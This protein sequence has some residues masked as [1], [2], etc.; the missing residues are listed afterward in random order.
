MLVAILGAVV[1]AYGYTRAS[2]ATDAER[3]QA[4]RRTEPLIGQWV[5]TAAD[6][7]LFR[8]QRAVEPKLRAGVFIGSIRRNE[9]GLRWKRGLSPSRAGAEPVTVVL[10]LEDELHPLWADIGRDGVASKLEETLR[11]IVEELRRSPVTI[12]EF[13]LDYDCPERRLD[14]YAHVLG[15]L[16]LGSLRH[17]PLWITSMPTHL[18]AKSYFLRLTGVVDGHVLQLFDTGLAATDSNA[19]HVASKLGSLGLPFRYGVG[20]F[21]RRGLAIATDHRQWLALGKTHL[22]GLPHYSGRWVFPAGRRYEQGFL[23]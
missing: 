8:H 9:T 12:E 7:E 14:D 10:R 1:A 2:R 19:E 4:E 22:E 18:G 16:K 13:Q 21:E 6:V 15:R 5:W 3:A 11:S 17:W 23:E 20:A